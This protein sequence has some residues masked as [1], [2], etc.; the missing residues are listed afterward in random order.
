MTVRHTDWFR[1]PPQHLLDD[2]LADDR[3]AKAR[4]LIVVRH[5]DAGDKSTWE[6]PDLRRPL[7]PLGRRQAEGLVFQ[8][9]DYPIERIVC[10]PTLRCLQTVEPLARDRLL[11]IEPV[12]A[13][14]VDAGPAEVRSV[15]WEWQL[16]NVM[17]CTHGEMIRQLFR[18]LVMEELEVAEPL[19]WPKGST[20]LL[21]RT[22][23]HVHARFL[24]PL[25]LDPA[26]TR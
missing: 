2:Q 17:L 16:D 22:R 10:S 4:M 14:G 9:E 19:H 11:E 6:G 13:L 5:G 15:F 23:Q 3:N 20:W 24:A 1:N 8:L 7:S 25:A 26:H 21:R 12:A 18:Q